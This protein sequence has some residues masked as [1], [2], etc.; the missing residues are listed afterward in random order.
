MTKKQVAILLIMLNM[1]I[2]A[3]LVDTTLTIILDFPY[4]RSKPLEEG[5]IDFW[6]M[7]EIMNITNLNISIEKEEIRVINETEL[8]Y[9]TLYYT[10]EVYEGRE[11]RIYA[12]Y[13]ELVDAPKPLPTLVFQHGY[14]GNWK[15]FEE[16]LIQFAVQGDIIV[17][18]IDAPGASGKSTDYPPDSPENIINATQ[19][20]KGVYFYHV[21][22]A[23]MRGITYLTTLD[24]VDS[25]NIFMSGA[26]M[27]GVM[28]FIV[29]AI[30]DRVKAIMPIVAAGNYLDS[31]KSGSLA[32]GMMPNEISMND[33]VARNFLRWFDIHHYAKRIHKPVLYMVTTHDEFFTIISANDTYS[34]IPSKDKTLVIWPNSDHFGKPYWAEKVIDVGI[35]WIKS[36]LKKARYPVIKNL[37]YKI[38]YYGLFTEVHVVLESENLSDGMLPVIVNRQ[39]QPLEQWR[40]IR[41]KEFGGNR[42]KATIRAF[43]SSSINFY[44]AIAKYGA[45]N[46]PIIFASSFLIKIKIKPLLFPVLC[47]ILTAI[48][49]GIII[50]EKVKVNMKERVICEALLWILSVAFALPHIIIGGRAELT[51]WDLFERYRIIL[52]LN[53]GI[54]Y[55]VVILFGISF[56][57]VLYKPW[58]TIIAVAL[59]EIA[60]LM[61]VHLALVSLIDGIVVLYVGY[62]IFIPVIILI[63]VFVIKLIHRRRTT[64]FS[65]NP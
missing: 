34:T 60:F 42:Y 7:S 61:G 20:P 29:G 11:I 47:I 30:D 21:A 62:S 44:G 9:R 28:S 55:L 32:N 8:L 25:S 33:P 64:Y 14:G 19:S 6:P 35:L 49:S 24:S 4:R 5:F 48:F 41:C 63:L 59:G 45:D 58:E 51:I 23:I 2:G 10:S 65:F 22:I 3:L 39:G 36:V 56:G 50:T 1:I 38:F 52:N 17:F 53:E 46:H 27:G 54:Y 37:E 43:K 12:L 31:V 13:L 15:Q 40:I 16:F 57:F 26:S 18:A